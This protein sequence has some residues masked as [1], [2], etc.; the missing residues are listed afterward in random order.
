MRPLTFSQRI[1]Q[2]VI[3]LEAG[4]GPLPDSVTSRRHGVY[5]LWL[6]DK[7]YRQL[8]LGRG[9]GGVAYA[10]VA[11]GTGGLAKRFREEWRPPHSG[12]SSPRRTLG[13]L[14]RR[15]LKLKPRPRPGGGGKNF[16]YFGFGEDGE[17]ALSAWIEAHAL[18]A[19]AEVNV[20]EWIAVYRVEDIETALIER[21]RP[22]LN[23]TKWRNPAR[24]RISG[25]R[26]SAEWAALRWAVRERRRAEKL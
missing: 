23:M 25:A 2:L 8:G 5:A 11:G 21:L 22:P 15:R 20:D 13:A 19:C 7:A 9:V 10:G 6:D 1:D 18:Y 24:G 4:K 16:K 26:K 12:R 3:E 17:A 14:L